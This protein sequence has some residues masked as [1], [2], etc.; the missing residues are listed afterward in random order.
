MKKRLNRKQYKLLFFISIFLL[1]IS[2]A[3]ITINAS[4]IEYEEDATYYH[5]DINEEFP[6][7]ISNLYD[8]GYITF[9][10][11][12]VLPIEFYIND[13]VHYD[14]RID[15]VNGGLANLSAEYIG[16]LGMPTTQYFIESGLWN[17]DVT[18][19]ILLDEGLKI[20][21]SQLELLLDFNFQYTE[22]YTRENLVL[23]YLK[24]QVLNQLMTIKFSSFRLFNDVESYIKDNLDTLKYIAP[25]Y[26]DDPEFSNSILSGITLGYGPKDIDG[27]RLN[28][29]LPK[30]SF[31]SNNEKYN[32]YTLYFDVNARGE[33]VPIGVIQYFV[34]YNNV[35]VVGNINED[36]SDN[37]WLNNNYKYITIFSNFGLYDMLNLSLFGEFNVYQYSIGFDA[38]GTFSDLFTGIAN[39]PIVVLSN[40]LSFNL[41]GW[42]AFAVLCSII[43]LLVIIWLIKKLVGGR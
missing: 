10:Y 39:V 8:L 22:D 43:T 4:G 3:L 26:V 1:T 31:N 20:K 32:E 34:R 37:V 6:Y 13:F 41:F 40:L 16:S 21:Q 23:R 29:N 9:T 30:W 36:Y 25:I 28:L 11:S 19:E 24:Y 5:F 12:V 35:E 18:T 14:L 38:G 2:S 27:N 15:I 17:N 7:F 42:T 33:A